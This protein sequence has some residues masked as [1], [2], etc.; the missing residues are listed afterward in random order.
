MERS[1]E[2]EDVAVALAEVRPAP[3]DEFAAELDERVAAGFPRRSRFG[4]FSTAGL[5]DRIG[6]RSPM[7]LSF[8]VAA[9]ALVAIAVVTAIIAN[10]GPES[11]PIAIDSGPTTPR[12]SGQG[13]KGA[14]QVATPESS[15]GVQYSEIIPFAAAAGSSG[16]GRT[17]S[18]PAVD[19]SEAGSLAN[20]SHHREIERSAEI[21]LLAD[22]ADVADDSAKVF[23]A[24]HDAHGIVLHSTTTAGRHA[25]ANFDLL[26]PSA[27]LGDALAAFSAIDE[28]SSRHEAT[29]DIT[30]PTVAL[31]EQL[32]D[33]QA[34]I[35][36]LL[37]QLA[38]AETEAESEAIGFQ[39]HA[40][41]QHAA[42]LRARL[43]QLQRRTTYSRVSVR[44][45]S[46]ASTDSG[47]AWGIDDAFGDAGHILGVA[48]G[49]TVVGLAIV[50][51]L[52]LIALLAWL[53][54]RLLLRTRRERAL[55][56]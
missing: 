18:P 1:R 54:R 55:D 13:S 17:V 20:L 33:S 10:S 6:A 21:G 8:A 16:S 45:E 2:Y 15:G 28:V 19:S 22:P 23:R 36:G 3:R 30:A 26:I 12:P 42:Q 46:G 41:R 52:L 47:G 56:A 34:K 9:V 31:G 7:R 48:A 27:R 29:A 32:Q 49:V 11:R 39:L 43:A 51:P 53:V 37:A 35:D 38:G 25:G 5:A 40:E 24:V 44:I 14:P 4:R 50:A